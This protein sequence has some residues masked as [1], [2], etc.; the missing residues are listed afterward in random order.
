MKNSAH[1][2]AELLA[3]SP[4]AVAKAVERTLE[5]AERSPVAAK[6]VVQGIEK[7]VKKA[8]A[9][10]EGL[11]MWMQNTANSKTRKNGS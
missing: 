8:N 11:A 3:A 5:R 4:P 1:A 7:A 2:L 10:N 9:F 6:A